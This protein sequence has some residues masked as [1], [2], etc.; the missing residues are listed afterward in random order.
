MLVPW[1]YEVLCHD[2]A[3]HLQT[4]YI[5]I[6]LATHLGVRES[7]CLAKVTGNHAAIELQGLQDG[8]LDAVWLRVRILAA[9]IVAEVWPPLL[10]D[11]HSLLANKLAVGT[12]CLPDD[13]SLPIP[14]R[15]L[16][17]TL[18]QLDILTILIHHLF[19]RPSSNAEGEKRQKA[20]LIDIFH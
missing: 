15:P 19:C 9:A 11:E 2:I 3:T 5:G 16:K 17:S 20:N 10:T 6:K 4:S 7:T 14:Q 8:F 18:R 13:I 1:I 12:A